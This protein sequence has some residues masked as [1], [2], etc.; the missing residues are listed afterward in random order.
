[1][2]VFLCLCVCSREFVYTGSHECVF[3]CIWRQED[4]FRYSLGHYPPWFL[5]Q[6]LSLTLELVKQAKVFG[7]QTQDV[8]SPNNRNFSLSSPGITKAYHL[9]QLFF[10]FKLGGGGGM[11]EI[12]SSCLLSSAFPM[13]S[14]PQPCSLAAPHALM[15]PVF[16]I[17]ELT[18]YCWYCYLCPKHDSIRTNS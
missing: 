13:E 9:T 10:F 6:S 12:R 7:Q 14:F 17:L 11:F 3:Q 2:S 5:R 8:W 4:K 16:L 1:M 18:W 15:S